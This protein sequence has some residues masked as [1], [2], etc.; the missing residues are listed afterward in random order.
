MPGRCGKE[1]SLP[2]GPKT[3]LEIRPAGVVESRVESRESRV[4]G[5]EGKRE[6]GGNWKNRGPVDQQP[7]GVSGTRRVPSARRAMHVQTTTDGTRRVP[8]TLGVWDGSITATRTRTITRSVRSTHN[9]HAEREQY[10]EKRD[11]KRF[12]GKNELCTSPSRQN[13]GKSAARNIAPKSFARLQLR[14]T[15]SR[16]FLFL[17]MPPQRTTSMSTI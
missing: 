7:P 6:R 8:D 10:I 15:T 13:S 1:Q 3:T 9:R 12:A 17:R 5:R 4:E 14:K 2:R 11:T 16:R